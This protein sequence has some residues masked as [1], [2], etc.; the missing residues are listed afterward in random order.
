MEEFLN[1]PEP[2]ILVPEKEG[3]KKAN[4]GRRSSMDTA[5]FQSRLCAKDACL[6]RL[7]GSWVLKLR[8]DQLQQKGRFRFDR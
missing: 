2:G 5:V 1:N 8:L 7:P 3:G 4:T 6:M